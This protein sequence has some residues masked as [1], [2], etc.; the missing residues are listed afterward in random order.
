ML[1]DRGTY[2][3]MEGDPAEAFRRGKLTLILH[4]EKLRGEFHFVRTKR[5]QGRDWLLFKGKDEFASPGYAP[6]GTR[7]VKSGRVI[8]EIRA[9]QDARW[10][11]AAPAPAAAPASPRRARRKG[12]ADPFPEPFRPMLAETARGS[13]SRA[14]WLFEIKWDGVRALGFV[15]RHGATQEIAL[16]SRTLHR[17]N[18][19]FPD[20]VASLAVLEA[21]VAMR[22]IQ[23]LEQSRHAGRQK[24]VSRVDV[25][26]RKFFNT[27]LQ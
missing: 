18:A 11:P 4:G 2:E 6:G 17:L 19:P 9:E 15:R 13:F 3:C 22:E 27:D 21:D 26:R 24:S 12:P 20:V 14:G 8:E 5:N 1:W 16:Y 23:F 7:S 10:T 25:I